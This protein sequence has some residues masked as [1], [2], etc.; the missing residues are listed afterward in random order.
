[1][2]H[3]ISSREFYG[4]MFKL[5]LPITVQNLVA[6]SLNMVDTIMIGQLGQSELTAVGLSNQLFFLMVLFLFGTYSGASIFTSQ[7]WGKKDI[8][9]IHRILGIAIVT[10]ILASLVF[11]LG[12]MF[13][14]ATVLR[15]FINN[16]HVVQLGAAYLRIVSFSYVITSI[17][18]AYGFLC[19]SVEQAKLPMYVS[20]ACLCCN[21]IL[22]YLLIFGNHGF[23]IG[24][25]HV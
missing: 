22:N 5:A 13:F 3:L 4:T 19:R 23:Q 12:A 7:F 16:E 25:A 18:F 14:P 1:M 9:N 17:T 8:A 20:G 21:T 24:R 6:S 2:K 11:T 10:G 15:L